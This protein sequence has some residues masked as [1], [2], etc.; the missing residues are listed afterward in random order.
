M[1]HGARI[2]LRI[3]NLD[4]SC[5]LGMEADNDESQAGPEKLQDK[6][7]DQYKKLIQLNPAA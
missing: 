2:F 4:I 1:V 6:P 7:K 3:W 5:F